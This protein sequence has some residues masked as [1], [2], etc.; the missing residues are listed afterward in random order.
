MKMKIEVEKLSKYKYC[1]HKWHF[2]PFFEFDGNVL[3]MCHMMA[4]KVIVGMAILRSF[5]E[6]QRL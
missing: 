2:I 6:S 1:T 4:I 5:R 3:V